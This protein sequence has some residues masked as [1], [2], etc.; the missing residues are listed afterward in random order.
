MRRHDIVEVA[1]SWVG[2]PFSHHQRLKEV[3]ADCVG[4]IN[5]VGI[6][7]QAIDFTADRWAPFKGYRPLPRPKQVMRYCETFL[8][9]S[10]VACS[11]L[12]P[13]ASIG[14]IAWRK[15]LTL[16]FVIRSVLPDGRASVIHADRERGVIEHALV[17][18]WRRL[19]HSWWD[20]PGVE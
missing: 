1:K 4:F 11:E 3:G 17:D 10:E 18:D 15:D 5:G 16:H 20:F 14:V 8:A 9:R 6:E 19:I 13:I 7:T 2:T 12:A